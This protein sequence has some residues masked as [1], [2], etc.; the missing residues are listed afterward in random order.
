MEVDVWREQTH[1]RMAFERGKPK[2]KLEKARPRAEQARH[3]SVRFKPDPQIFG[4]KAALQAR[5]PVQDVALEGLSVR[6]RRNPLALRP[7]AAQRHRGRAGDGDVPFRRGPEGLS[8]HQ[9]RAGAT[10]VHPDIFTGSS[11]KTGRH[12][13]VEWAVAWS[14]DT[15]GFLNSYC[16]TI[17]TPDGGTHEFGLRSALLRGLKDH[18]ARVGQDKRAAP[19]PAK[20]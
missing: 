13:A 17:P 7:G 1:Y 12:G 4:A 14:A 20:T 9:H 6:R 5:A 18:A 11:G 15:D 8:R 2:G 16:N 10:L 19:S 3:A